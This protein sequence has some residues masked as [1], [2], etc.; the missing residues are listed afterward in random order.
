MPA[1]GGPDC[2][3]LFLRCL[4]VCR[5][6]GVAVKSV[7]S[8]CVRVYVVGVGVLLVGWACNKG[9]PRGLVSR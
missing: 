8:P 4:D 3:Q 2:E 6:T 1:L 7:I 9:Y 5:V